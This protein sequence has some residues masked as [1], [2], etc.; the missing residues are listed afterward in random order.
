MS[1]PPSR[2]TMRT[3]SVLALLATCTALA[4]TISIR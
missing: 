2:A 4:I 3:L 1:R